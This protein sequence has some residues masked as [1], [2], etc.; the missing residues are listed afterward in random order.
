M[1]DKQIKIAMALEDL[2]CHGIEEVQYRMDIMNLTPSIRA[3]M[4]DAIAR[5]AMAKAVE[6]EG[7]PAA[8]IHCPYCPRS[9][10]SPT[11][12]AQHMKAKRRVSA[13]HGL[14]EGTERFPR[15]RRMIADL[16][17]IHI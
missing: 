14:S 9:F 1:A 12:L 6:C 10:A 3:P 5:R 4:W 17:L 15:S 13:A 11:A 2:V 16:S 7:K 8:M